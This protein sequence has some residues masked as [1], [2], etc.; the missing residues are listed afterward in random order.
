M[1]RIASYSLPE[2]EP[3]IFPF[4][5]DEVFVDCGAFIGDTVASYVNTI[6]YKYKRIY[7]YEI[8][9]KSIVEI[10]K[11]LKDLPNIVI[12]HK[13]TG[14]KNTTMDLIGLD[15]PHQANALSETDINPVTQRSEYKK[16]ETVK[17]VRLDDDIKEP[18]THIKIDV[19]G[20][21]KET[22]LGASGLIKKYHPKLHVDSYHK[23]ED[24]VD[25]PWLIREIDPSYTLYMR[26]YS[27][28]P[29]DNL[30][31]PSLTFQAI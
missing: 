2:V 24:L 19:E 31:N 16:Q 28:Y 25:I 29:F 18:V 4:Y 8:S 5:D 3:A 12:N 22:L 10:K 1:K 21:D 14:D 13:G 20:M 23:L 9:K 26:I 7:I 27:L 6:N 11:N 17:V 30:I 15:E